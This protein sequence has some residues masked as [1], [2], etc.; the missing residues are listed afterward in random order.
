MVGHENVI[1]CILFVEG[2]QC[3][4]LTGTDLLKNK[5]KKEVTL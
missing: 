2:D 5:F 1:E 3:Q 4:Y